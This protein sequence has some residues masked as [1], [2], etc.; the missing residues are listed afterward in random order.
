MLG[1]GVAGLYGLVRNVV[2][3][4]DLLKMR[5]NSQTDRDFPMAI[6]HM[7]RAARDLAVEQSLDAAIEVDEV[8][9]GAR[10]DAP[11]L[12]RLVTNLIGTASENGP[13][14]KDLLRDSQFNSLYHRA[15]ISSGR[16]DAALGEND[17]LSLLFTVDSLGVSKFSPDQLAIVRDFCLG[18]N[19]ELVSESYNRTP[20][21]PLARS[22][23]QK[24]ALANG[25]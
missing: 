15:A 13:G 10:S 11:M 4:W 23:H 3:R 12:N 1:V 17:I 6:H 5:S 9:R 16:D 2:R 14:K 21:P 20:E 18:L 24:L 8:I 7:N 25:Y 22:R 19:Q